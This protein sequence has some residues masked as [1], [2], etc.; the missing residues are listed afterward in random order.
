MQTEQKPQIRRAV[1]YVRL[2]ADDSNNPSLS[3]LNQEKICK[4]YA[5]RLGG[6][7]SAVYKDVNRSGATLERP[8]LVKLIKDAKQGMI[9]KIFIKDWSRL[10]RDIS[11]LRMIRKLLEK[12]LDVRIISS[13]GISD[14]KA[15]DV[16]TLSSDWFVQESRKKQEQ[17]HNLKIQEKVPL[18]RPPFGYKMSKKY[19]MFIPDGD[20]A[21]S[22]KEI[23]EQRDGGS[24]I[25]EIAN[26]FQMNLTTIYNILQNKTYLG[27]NCYKG[28]WSKGKHEPLIDQETFDRIQKERKEH[29]T[30]K[31]PNHVKIELPKIPSS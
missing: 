8:A 17:V 19:K 15:I 30:W 9:S 10:T 26:D 7:I 22:V 6:S 12:D 29:R 25:T 4:S 24:T 2:S 14:D 27:F 23:F 31:N 21:V 18:C 5:E 11:D 1:I 20:K 13:D 28:E 16:S 3:P